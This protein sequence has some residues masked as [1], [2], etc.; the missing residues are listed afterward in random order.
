MNRLYIREVIDK[1]MYEKPISSTTIRELFSVDK[2]NCVKEMTQYIK[3]YIDSQTSTVSFEISENV[4][5]LGLLYVMNVPKSESYAWGYL[6]FLNVGSKGNLDWRAAESIMYGLKYVCIVYD[7]LRCSVGTKSDGI[8]SSFIEVFTQNVL[9]RTEGKKHILKCKNV[10][11]KYIRE[12]LNYTLRDKLSMTAYATHDEELMEMFP[13]E[14][15]PPVS[16]V[17]KIVGVFQSKGTSDPEP[18]KRTRQLPK[19]KSHPKYGKR[20]R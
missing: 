11:D 13:R 19:E 18:I 8:K 12:H 20:K 2:S 4:A 14:K 17:S 1:A 7:E 6:Y 3:K 10:Y 15:R 5:L 9:R 16:I